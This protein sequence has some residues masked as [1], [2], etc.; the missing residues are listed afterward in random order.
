MR[1]AV[2]IV[3]SLAACAPAAMD[4][5]PFAAVT[6]GTTVAPTASATEHAIAPDAGAPAPS[7]TEHSLV[8]TPSIDQSIKAIGGAYQVPTGVDPT[9]LTAVDAVLDAKWGKPWYARLPAQILDKAPFEAWAAPIA[10][11]AGIEVD[12]L[13]DKVIRAHLLGALRKDWLASLAG[14]ENDSSEAEAFAW[15]LDRCHAAVAALSADAN[16]IR[17]KYAAF[18]PPFLASYVR[19]AADAQA[20]RA[21]AGTEIYP[22]LARAEIMPVVEANAVGLA[23]ATRD[24]AVDAE[25]GVALARGRAMIMADARKP[26]SP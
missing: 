20:A 4:A 26:K 9:G 18:K 13:T 25:I 2:L 1:T 22:M 7:A 24:R 11:S 10:R 15:L 19:D 3:A 8:A 17:P 21:V 12:G 23:N 6:P 14:T 16:A 5:G